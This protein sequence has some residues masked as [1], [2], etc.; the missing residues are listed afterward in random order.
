MKRKSRYRLLL[1][2]IVSA[3]LLT[4][5]CIERTMI[6]RSQPTGADVVL[7][8]AAV[9]KTP[10]TLKFQNYGKHQVIL[11]AKGYQREE[12][13]QPIVAPIYEWF[14]IDFFV[15][16]IW[17]WTVRDIHFCDYKLEP[18]KDVNKAALS[19]RAEDL[20]KRSTELGAAE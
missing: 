20:K 18:V 15:E 7:D 11:S 3:A 13:L 5:G 17:P 9:G 19:T 12:F 6:I 14:P 8:G 4:P 1:A 2:L 10:V 16:M